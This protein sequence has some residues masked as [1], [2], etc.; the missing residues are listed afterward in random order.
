MRVWLYPKQLNYSLSWI[1]F[2]V[3]FSFLSF[4]KEFFF[5]PEGS[6]SIHYSELFLFLLCQFLLLLPVP[7]QMVTPFWS[8]YR[9][10]PPHPPQGWLGCSFFNVSNVLCGFLYGIYIFV[11]ASVC[12][13]LLDSKLFEDL[14]WPHFCVLGIMLY[15]V[16]SK[17]LIN[18][19]ERTHIVRERKEV[20]LL[21][22]KSCPWGTGS[23]WMTKEEDVPERREPAKGWG[24]MSMVCVVN[25]ED[26][27]LIGTFFL[28][29]FIFSII[30]GLVFCQFLL[31]SKM[32]Q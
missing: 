3:I 17:C 25:S 4:L 22:E 23:I 24:G 2:S 27:C 15:L 21:K 8:L 13:S 12:F 10:S 14:V 26:I 20:I 29:F 11:I 28:M 9:T 19:I 6:L 16:Y 32:T 31:F 30:V 18:V 7:D 5:S 1:Y